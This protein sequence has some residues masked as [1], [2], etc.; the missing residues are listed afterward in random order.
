MNEE[1]ETGRIEAFSDGVFAVAITLLVLDIKVPTVPPANSSFSL[2]RELLG[3]WPTYLA[4]VTSF[5]TILIMWINHHRVFGQI[6]RSDD[7]F[8]ILN[9]LLLMC[10]SVIPFSTSLVSAYI[11]QPD[12]RLAVLVYAGTS[13]FMAVCFNALWRYAARDGRLLARDH[14]PQIADGI[15]KSYRFGPSLYF[16]VFCLGFVSVI[17]S[18]GLCFLLALFFTIPPRKHA[19]LA[20]RG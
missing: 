8:L 20:A 14:D 10:V 4:F 7:T 2:G 12:A 17:V 5:L 15:T 1:K 3:Q 16:V 18:M 19:L 13:F 6:K 9:G 11:R